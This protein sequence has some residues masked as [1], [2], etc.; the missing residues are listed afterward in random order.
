MSTHEETFAELIEQE[1]DVI[2]FLKSL[3]KKERRKLAKLVMEEVKAKH[4]WQNIIVRNISSFKLKGTEK[5]REQVLCAAI[6]CLNKTEFNRLMRSVRELRAFLTSETVEAKVLPW[7]VPSWYSAVVNDDEFWRIDYPKILRLRDKGYLEPSDELIAVP[8]SRYLV[9]VEWKNR[10][11]IGRYYPERLGKHPKTLEYDIW[12]LFEVTSQIEHQGSYA[13]FKEFPE[14]SNPWQVA[15]LDLIKEGKLDRARVLESAIL[16]STKGFERSLSKWFWNLINM[17][18]PSLPELLAHQDALI[19]SLDCPHSAIQNEVLRQ[20]KKIATNL[21]FRQEAFVD[22]APSL[23]S[24]ETKSIVNSTLMVL[25]RIAKTNPHLR[26]QTCT[27]AMGTFFQQDAKLQLRAAKLIAKS[28]EEAK[29]D[30]SEM[31][32]AYEDA[33]YK[34]ARDHLADFFPEETE[35]QIDIEDVEE[36]ALPVAPLAI[37]GP[38]NAIEPL[39]DFDD[40]VFFVSQVLDNNED[41]HFDLFLSYLPKLHQQVNKEN[42][43]KLI[44]VLNRAVDVT[45]RYSEWNTSEIEDIAAFYLCDYAVVLARAYPSQLKSYTYYRKDKRGG[46]L[47]AGFNRLFF[48]N[49]FAPLD[50]IKMTGAIYLLFKHLT[51]RSKQYLE[52]ENG[53]D[54]LSTPTHSPCWLEPKV[55][56]DRIIAH[57]RVSKQVLDIDLSIALLRLPQTDEDYSSLSP[58]IDQI[59]NHELR[60][61]MQ[62]VLGIKPLDTIKIRQPSSW[63]AAVLSKGEKQDIDAFRDYCENSLTKETCDYIWGVGVEEYLK[64]EYDYLTS[65]AIQKK[66]FRRSLT[67]KAKKRSF[68]SD[69]FFGGIRNLFNP[70]PKIDNNLY[71]FF[72]FKKRSYEPTL[73]TSDERRILFLTPN[74]PG[75]VLAEMLQNDLKESTTSSEMTKRNMQN[76]L[77]GL[78]QIWV[79]KDFDEMTYLFVGVSMLCSDKTSRELAA[80]LWCQAHAQGLMDHFRLGFIIGRL[81]RKDYAPLKRFTDLIVS[82]MMSLGAQYNAAL[83]ELLEAMI[84]Q[85]DPAPMRGLKKLLTL[86]YEVKSERPLDELAQENLKHW[87]AT[88]SLAGIVK[89]LM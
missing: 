66:A 27:V 30:L 67:I 11:H 81:Q 55:L 1:G 13:I 79:R 23:L 54:L 76:L 75:P 22:A 38:H 7:F 80:G 19:A 25:E 5:E 70:K 2:A 42:V 63:L 64:N 65:S 20:V 28:G 14:G 83:L 49:R 9:E 10:K 15:F 56:I 71:L 21:S 17:M 31:L 16:T 68:A 34:D 6:I 41:Y 58:H 36:A 26:E 24:S 48:T 40:L 72:E 53:L 87:R 57:R 69:S 33:I 60:D 88:S 61:L 43:H 85:L 74:N 32:L 35:P 12:T 3:E 59:R 29:E 89:K 37:I 52:A 73:S 84:G 47:E 77:Q 78:G 8:L 46:I 50:Q 51:L 39:S 18:E 62:Y 45:A 44:P 86:L 4:E 82:H